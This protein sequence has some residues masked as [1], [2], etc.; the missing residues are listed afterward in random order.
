M[1]G[2][3]DTGVITSLLSSVMNDGLWREQVSKAMTPTV[4][5]YIYIGTDRQ[6]ANEAQ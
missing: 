4:S 3:H 6:R 5:V 1:Q 2:K